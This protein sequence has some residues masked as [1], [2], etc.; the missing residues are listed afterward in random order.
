ME[1]PSLHPAA[2]ATPR[3]P[4]PEKPK[5][6]SIVARRMAYLD[7]ELDLANG[8]LETI[9]ARIKAAQNITGNDPT[10]AD[11]IARM[12]ARRVQ[13]VTRVDE[14]SRLR[15]AA[16]AWLEV[17]GPVEFVK[18]A[19]KIPE[20]PEALKAAIEDL[21]IVIAQTKLE[22]TEVSRAPTAITNLKAQVTAYVTALAAKGTPPTC[23]IQPDGTVKIDFSTAG[24]PA[25]AIH[26]LA[27][28]HPA[29]MVERLVKEI[30]EKQAHLGRTAMAANERRD[31]LAELK[32][33]LEKAERKDAALTEAAIEA[34]ITG[35]RYRPDTDVSTF[36]GVRALRPPASYAK[37][38]S[39]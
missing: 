34:E 19:G 12:T 33:K 32:A 29:V 15:N 9:R 26:Y 16:K 23:S 17:A 18:A 28:L 1:R 5:T 2:A 24:Y 10:A 4:R 36:L 6:P 13:I 31:R 39:A 25:L 3:P 30:E 22:I 11:A 7:A 8:M 35:M 37:I 21:R 14:L 20:T 38:L 27:W